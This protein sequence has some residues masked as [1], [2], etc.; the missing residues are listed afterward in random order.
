GGMTG[1]REKVGD[2]SVFTIVSPGEINGFHIVMSGLIALIGIVTQPHIMGV[3]AAGKTEMDGRFGFATGNLI[4]RFCTVAWMLVGLAGIALYPE[5]VG[6]S[7]A[8]SPDL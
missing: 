1:L 6:D 2:P 3:C 5:L 8:T 7:P 4:K